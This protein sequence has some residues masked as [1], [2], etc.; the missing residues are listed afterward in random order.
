[1]QR[2]LSSH[3]DKNHAGELKVDAT[4]SHAKS[5]SSISQDPMLT[6]KKNEMRASASRRK[7]MS[8]EKARM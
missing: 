7:K 4:H 3:F 6:P 1:M 2:N 5:L 8:G